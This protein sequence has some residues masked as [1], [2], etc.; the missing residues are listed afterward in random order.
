MTVWLSF[1]WLVQH[2]CNITVVP[3]T[4]SHLLAHEGLARCLAGGVRT[5]DFRWDRR[6]YQVTTTVLE[7]DSS[8]PLPFVSAQKRPCRPRVHDALRR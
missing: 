2:A 5:C 7:N 4:L 8:T 6:H 3:T 1:P